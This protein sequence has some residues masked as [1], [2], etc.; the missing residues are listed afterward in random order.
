[1]H[2]IGLSVI[3]CVTGVLDLAIVIEGSE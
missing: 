1:M 3:I 2:I